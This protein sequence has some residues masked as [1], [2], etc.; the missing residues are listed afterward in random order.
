[1]TMPAKRGRPVVLNPGKLTAA[2]KMLE[3]GM[4][5]NQVAYCLDVSRS[6][7]YR[8]FPADSVEVADLFPESSATDVELIAPPQVEEKIPQEDFSLW[9]RTTFPILFPPPKQ[10]LPKRAFGQLRSFFSK[11]G[12][13]TT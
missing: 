11:N 6:V 5:R 4:S 8:A 9:L 2:R 13:S 10:S 3:Q 7:I 1:M 12:R